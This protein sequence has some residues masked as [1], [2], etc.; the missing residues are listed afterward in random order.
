MFMLVRF[1]IDLRS[2]S[3]TNDYFLGA[4]GYVSI[5]GTTDF[6]VVIRTMVIRGDSKSS[7]SPPNF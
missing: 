1:L 7:R 6:S 5:D 2:V 4:F 3:D